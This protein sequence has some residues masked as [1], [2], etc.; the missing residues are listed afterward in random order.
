M[1]FTKIFLSVRNLKT[2][3]PNEASPRYI[4]AHAVTTKASCGC[5]TWIPV[6]RPMMRTAW[7]SLNENIIEDQ[8]K[9][10]STMHSQRIAP[11]CRA[12]RPIIMYSALKTNGQ[13]FTN[14]NTQCT[15]QSTNENTIT[16]TWRMS[17]IK[18]SCTPAPPSPAEHTL[19][20]PSMHC[21]YL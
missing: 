8:L 5:G 16:S 19:N 11:G 1:Y 13:G 4:P 18:H 12:I 15:H 9:W 2:V 20:T 3:G 10:C 7:K 6:I 14:N 17:H 21:S